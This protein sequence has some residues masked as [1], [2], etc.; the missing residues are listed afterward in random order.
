M[1]LPIER[2]SVTF[3]ALKRKRKLI[4]VST[5]CVSGDI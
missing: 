5:R 3:L 1:A 2:F 4:Y